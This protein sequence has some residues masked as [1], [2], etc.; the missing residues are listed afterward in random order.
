MPPAARYLFMPGMAPP[1][2]GP[3]HILRE[4]TNE[5]HVVNEVTTPAEARAAI[6]RMADQGIRHVK[7]W[8]DDRGGTYPKL[9]PEVYTAIVER[10]TRAR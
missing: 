9:T 2:G 4:A 1:N 8:V 3:D 6:Q 5:L 10:R 7:M